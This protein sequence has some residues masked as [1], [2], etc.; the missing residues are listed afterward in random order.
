MSVL[1]NDF[2]RQV[3]CLSVSSLGW[4]PHHL[5]IHHP[6]YE[7]RMNHEYVI[8]LV[9]ILLSTGTHN[10]RE[11]GIGFYFVAHNRGTRNR[12]CEWSRKG[13]RSI[14]LKP[15]CPNIQYWD[16][17]LKLGI[18]PLRVKSLNLRVRDRSLRM[19]YGSLDLHN[20]GTAPWV[21]AVVSGG[22]SIAVVM[23][24]VWL[25]FFS[26]FAL[27]SPFYCRGCHLFSQ[28]APKISST[29]FKVYLILGL[30]CFKSFNGWSCY[31]WMRRYLRICNM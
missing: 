21:D 28:T 9:L 31:W 5:N 6:P 7:D 23:S 2:L 3:P 4:H 1:G 16:H 10:L 22:V 13:V 25:A 24:W 17:H 19:C 29:K 30:L 15:G 18:C 27:T 26:F 11:Q 14:Y 12:D 8:W 20:Y